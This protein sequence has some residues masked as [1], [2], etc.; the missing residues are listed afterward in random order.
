M[1]TQRESVWASYLERK[2]V[3]SQNLGRNTHLER[4]V[5]SLSE[6]EYSNKVIFIS[7]IGQSF[8][9]FAYIWPVILFLSLHLTDPQ[10]LPKMHV[11][12]FAKTNPTAHAYCCMSTLITGWRPP[13]FLIPKKPFSS[14]AYREVFLDPRRGHLISQQQ[15]S[16]SF[17]HNLCPW[18]GWVRTKPEFY[19]T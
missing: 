18:S 5:G 14:C 16:V 19:S 12:V 1:H 3:V 13:P 10:A 8:Q 11:Q 17:C 15:S 9:A 7:F 6:E 2:N 4:S